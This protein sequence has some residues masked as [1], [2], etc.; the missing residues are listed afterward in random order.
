MR[1]I[2]LRSEFWDELG[3]FGYLD[4]GCRIYAEA[5]AA[6]LGHRADLAYVVAEGDAFGPIV[7]HAVVICGDEVY[8]G[9]G[10]AP[11][12]GYLARYARLEHRSNAT[13]ELIH[14][15]AVEDD[16]RLA[17]QAR[18]LPENAH[19]SKRLANAWRA[20]LGEPR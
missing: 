7:D 5:A 1:E 6:Y 20:E 9:D 3:D 11:L 8:D 17:E 14:A 18:E 2:A 12:E 13:L 19:L 4:G 15:D 16:P 10:A